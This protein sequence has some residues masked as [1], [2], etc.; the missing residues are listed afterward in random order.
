MYYNARHSQRRTNKGR[1]VL[2]GH[3]SRSW[4]SKFTMIHA[5]DSNADSTRSVF[6]GLLSRFGSV[7]PVNGSIHIL[8]VQMGS[9]KKK[10]GTTCR[11][12]FPELGQNELVANALWTLW[13]LASRPNEQTISVA[14][15][16][17][18]NSTLN[19]EIGP[20][21]PGHGAG[22][23]APISEVP[24]RNDQQPGSTSKR[25]LSRIQS[26]LPKRND[27]QPRNPA[28]NL[29]S[30]LKVG[31]L[32]LAEIPVVQY[33]PWGQ[34]FHAGNI[35]IYIV[36]LEAVPGSLTPLLHWARRK[37]YLVLNSIIFGPSLWKWFSHSVV[38]LFQKLQNL[39]PH[40]RRRHVCMPLRQEPTI[41]R[42]IFTLKSSPSNPSCTEF[43]NAQNEVESSV[44]NSV[45]QQL[46]RY[47]C[48][49]I[50]HR[51]QVKDLQW[52]RHTEGFFGLKTLLD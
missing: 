9:V 48:I 28:K 25:V 17:Y 41:H 47:S 2:T 40:W 43:S 10:L 31:I 8:F 14:L 45:P 36:L 29:P 49:F 37:F 16:P 6:Q 38:N 52:D 11:N 34:E 23:R 26:Y 35:A 46:E 7:A 12:V 1:I 44:T 4:K 22:K 20:P 15:L 13:M 19:P 30:N 51:Q 5:I 50:L 3:C 21:F 24:M 42:T 33:G 32:M 27:E 18:L 39:R